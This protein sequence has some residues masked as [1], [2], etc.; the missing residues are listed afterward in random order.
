MPS[1][2]INIMTEA[3]RRAGRSLGRDFNDVEFLQAS[4]KGPADFM[5]AADLRAE[6]ILFKFLNEKRPGYSFLF[7]ERGEVTGTDKS[8]RWIVDPLDGTLNFLHAIPHFAVSIALERYGEL[9]AGVVYDVIKDEMFW[10]E[11][12]RGAYMNDRRLRVS[13]RKPEK[14]P[15]LFATGA[16]F[17]GRKGHARF[18]MELHKILPQSAGIRRMGSAALDLAYVAA[19]RVDGFW[20]RDL[21]SWDVAAGLVLV[22]EAGGKSQSLQGD[23]PAYR[24]GHILA[25]NDE[26]VTWLKKKLDQAEQNMGS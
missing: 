22:T 9:I 8:H 26:T 6:E 17:M 19:G 24:S 4:K 15:C 16:P 20:E 7:E 3:A 25:G 11:K 12:G 18:L 13:A 10:A 1:P 21:A 14:T 5:S 2:L 23:E